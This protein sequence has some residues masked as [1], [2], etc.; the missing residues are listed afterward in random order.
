MPKTPLVAVPV[1]RHL[2]LWAHS[3]SFQIAEHQAI[4]RALSVESA[5]TSAVVRWRA[6]AESQWIAIGADQLDRIVD[7]MGRQFVL[8]QS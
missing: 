1:D 3:L 2:A 6:L 4:A 7:E 5:W 8:A